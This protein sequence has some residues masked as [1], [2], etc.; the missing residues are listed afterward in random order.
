MELHKRTGAIIIL[1]FALQG[2]FNYFADPSMFIPGTTFDNYADF[3][4]YIEKGVTEDGTPVSADQQ[5][6]YDD[7]G[8]EISEEEALTSYIYDNGDIALTYL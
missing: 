1:T 7:L 6:Y 4:E 2:T 3:L 5:T 8:N